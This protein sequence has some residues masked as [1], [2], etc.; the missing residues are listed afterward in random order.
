[1][2]KASGKIKTLWKMFADRE[3]RHAFMDSHIRESIAA[4]VFF[5]RENRKWTQADLAELASTK[6]PA[7]SRIEKGEARLSLASLQAIA[8]AFDVALQVK[9]V[10]FSALLEE[11]EEGRPERYVPPFSDDMPAGLAEVTALGRT[12]ARFHVRSIR[13]EWTLSSQTQAQHKGVVLANA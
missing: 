9:F 12:Q 2:K 5:I 8:S 13:D 11:I 1:M 3:F 4:Q 10:P 6:Q 7:I